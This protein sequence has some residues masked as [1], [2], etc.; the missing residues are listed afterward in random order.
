VRQKVSLTIVIK[1]LQ[2]STVTQ[3]T[4]DKLTILYPLVEN[5]L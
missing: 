3:T 5:F 1:I 2:N 4:L